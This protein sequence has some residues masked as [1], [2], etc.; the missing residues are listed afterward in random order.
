MCDLLNRNNS[1]VNIS[2][3]KTPSG[4][5]S[6]HFLTSTERE[7]KSLVTELMTITAITQ[8]RTGNKVSCKSIHSPWCLSGF[9]FLEG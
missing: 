7:K 4:R 3:L 5:R 6:L 1:R 8:V 9:G 2:T